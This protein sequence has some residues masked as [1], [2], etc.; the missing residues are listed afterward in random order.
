MINKIEALKILS[1]DNSYVSE[2]TETS[3]GEAKLLAKTK[4][5]SKHDFFLILASLNLLNAAI[6]RADFKKKIRYYQIKMNV[7]RILNHLLQLEN[8]NYDINFYINPL[9]KCAY[10]EIFN[11]QFSFHNILIDDRMKA[12]IDSEKNIIKPWQEI[13]LQRIAGELFNLAIDMRD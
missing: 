13:R 11:L 9:E 12:F 4:A 2:I 5:Y 8:H 10:V 6:K 1:Q 7:S 3:V